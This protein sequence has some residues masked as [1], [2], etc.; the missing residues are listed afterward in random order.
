MQLVEAKQVSGVLPVLRIAGT[1]SKEPHLQFLKVS[2]VCCNGA[3]NGIY[4][5]V[6][7]AGT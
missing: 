4:T 6:Q 5:I 2:S 1:V 7:P 3:H